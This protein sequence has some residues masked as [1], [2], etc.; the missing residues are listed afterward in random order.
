MREITTPG[1]RHK[2][3]PSLSCARK[4]SDFELDL[5]NRDEI[6]TGSPFRMSKS[7]SGTGQEILVDLLI[8]SC[9]G[10]LW[11]YG[12]SGRY[13]LCL[14]N[15]IFLVTCFLPAQVYLWIKW[16]MSDYCLGCVCGAEEPSWM[17][18]EVRNH[19][20]A[21]EDNIWWLQLWCRLHLLLIFFASVRQVCKELIAK[22]Q[23]RQAGNWA[24]KENKLLGWFQDTWV[25]ILPLHLFCSVTLV[26]SCPFTV[27]L[28]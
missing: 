3:G 1:S 11:F 10:W 28:I 21:A 4:H 16:W 24:A 12:T 7:A 27:L 15:C 22:G 20:I 5:N 18:P 17:D 2:V 19:P 13:W 14:L 26:K 6:I 8:W 25:V 23:I 9:Q